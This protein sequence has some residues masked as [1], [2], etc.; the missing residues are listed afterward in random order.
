MKKLISLLAMLFVVSQI[1][2]NLFASK[3]PNPETGFTPE[4]KKVEVYYFHYSRRCATCEAVENVTKEALDNLYPDQIKDG[5]VSFI[6][7]NIE[8][9]DNETFAEEMGADGQTLMVVCGEE[10]VNLTN[11]AF[12]NARTKPEKL[13]KKIKKTVDKFIE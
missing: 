5:S 9:G 4:E 6:S 13:R 11:D 3:N 7:I 1:N 10:K 12:M 2:I 8:E